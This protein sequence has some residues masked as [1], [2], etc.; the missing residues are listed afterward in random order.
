MQ[1]ERYLKQAEL[2][3][4]IL[5]HIAREEIFALKGGTAINF[6]WRDFP[7]LSVDIDLTYLKIQDREL[8]LVEISDRLIS[9]EIRLGRILPD[10]KIVQKKNNGKVDGLIIR[11]EEALVKVE[12]NTIIRGSVFPV[13]NKN[14][15]ARA[16]EKFELTTSINTLSFGDLYGGKICA[17][18]DRQHP[19]DLFDIKL[20]MENEGISVG[21]VKA[22]VFYLVSHDRPMVEVLNP[23]LRDIEQTFE[24]EFSGMTAED[25]K[26]AD[27]ISVRSKLI[28]KMKIS[29]TDEQ[30]NF[31]LS[32]KNKKPDWELSSIKGIENFPS[33]K[34]K[35]M[36]IEKMDKKKHKLAYD[37]LKEYLMG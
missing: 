3:L 13:V 29:L 26:L 21:T 4:K 27:L 17:A 12:A 15:C 14:L 2:I 25:V 5:P 8:S 24:N 7:R 30:K 23:G 16:E 28:A 20:L 6:F 36:N 10:V 33:V 22:F 1:N 37:K 32:F 19:R 9:I 35:L 11:S 31:I 34:W 18:L